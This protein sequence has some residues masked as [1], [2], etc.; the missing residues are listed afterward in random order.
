MLAE[1]S[2]ARLAILTFASGLGAAGVMLIASPLLRLQ[3]KATIAWSSLAVALA[4]LCGM[5][6]GERT[7]VGLDAGGP[8]TL[9]PG[10][11]HGLKKRSGEKKSSSHSHHPSAKAGRPFYFL[12]EHV[13]KVRRLDSLSFSFSLPAARRADLTDSLERPPGRRRYHSGPFRVVAAAGRRL[14]GLPP[15]AVH[16]ARQRAPVPAHAGPDQGPGRQVRLRV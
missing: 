5:I 12:F 13:G 4:L 10:E 16:L 11:R 2:L 3:R 14:Q 6:A 1:I 7:S 15:A 8:S 9:Q